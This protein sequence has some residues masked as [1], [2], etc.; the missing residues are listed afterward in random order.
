MTRGTRT[1]IVVVLIL[2]AAIGVVSRRARDHH[3]PAAASANAAGSAKAEPPVASTAPAAVAPPV[4]VDDHGA[5]VVP[6]TAPHLP[7]PRAGQATVTVTGVG[8]LGSSGGRAALPIASIAKVM[9]AYLVLR[10]HPLTATG[11][12]PTLTVTAA[13]AAAYPHQRALDESLVPVTAGEKLTERQALE[14]LLLPSAD[15]IAQVLGRWDAGSVP[16]F[17]ATMNTRAR[18]LGMTHTRY[19][20]P[21]GLDPKTVSTVDDQLRLARAAMALPAFARIVAMRSARIPVAGTIGNRNTLLG[22]AGVNGVKTGSTHSAGGCLL[23]TARRTVAGHH[24]TIVGA[25][26]GQRGSASYLTEA[27]TATRRLVTAATA[28]IRRVTI[29]HAGDVVGTVPGTSARLTAAADVTVLGWP[30][31][32][33]QTAIRA[34]VPPGA[35]TGTVVGT[36]TV[37]GA[38]TPV[39]VTVL[40]AATGER[41]M[42][43]GD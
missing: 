39:T 30:G 43:S 22:T 32:R 6:G 7:W 8:G 35:A 41:R 3:A 1:T 34:R 38:G 14:A 9:T 10:D 31:L 42:R 20:D 15:N 37:T 25:V 18:A 23:F 24:I 4:T 33:F 36:L 27:F 26:L 19:T 12:G 29:V 28:A 13:E 21:S 17:V 2:A 11:S 5:Y 16:A 40:V